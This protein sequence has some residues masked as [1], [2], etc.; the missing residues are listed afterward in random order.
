M[1][2]AWPDRDGCGRPRRVGFTLVEVLL[3]VAV[4]A[5]LA[6]IVL[7]T[8]GRAKEKA[9]QAACLSN[10]RQLGLGLQL[11]L[12]D[13]HQRFPYAWTPAFCEPWAAYRNSLPMQ[14]E[15]AS[16]A[17]ALRPYLNDDRVWICPADIGDPWR[18][19]KQ[20][21]SPMHKRLGSSYIYAG[22]D[23]LVAWNPN[24]GST[25]AGKRLGELRRPSSV[26]LLFEY[27]PWHSAKLAGRL[28][29]PEQLWN[30]LFGDG[31]AATLKDEEAMRLVLKPITD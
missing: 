18:Q 3:V 9:K 19:P 14:P 10:L 6:A 31:H 23:Y 15:E 29:A 13:W 27:R 24:P 30:L 21:P 20:P 17:Y 8:L 25:V 26:V 4:V 5:V 12:G 28:H 7:P 1:A 2:Y 11:Y 22:L 16:V